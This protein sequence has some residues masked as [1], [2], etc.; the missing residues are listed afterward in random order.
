MPLGGK[1]ELSARVDFLVDFLLIEVSPHHGG[2]QV[3]PKI[4]QRW[5]IGRSHEIFLKAGV[6][7]IRANLR[8]F[9]SNRACQNPFMFNDNESFQKRDVDKAQSGWQTSTEKIT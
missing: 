9:R 5:M 7:G 1:P 4:F 6:E 8:N 3:G 2:Y